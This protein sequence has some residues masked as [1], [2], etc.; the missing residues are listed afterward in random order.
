M[1]QLSDE[2]Y[3]GRGRTRECF[4][5][6]RDPHR[7][8]KVDFRNLGFRQTEKEALYYAKLARLK[9]DLVYNFIP[10][11][12]GMVETSRG[13][14]GVFDLIADEGTTRAASTMRQYITDGSIPNDPESW[15]T[16]LSQF[17]NRLIESGVIV[18]DIRPANL[19]AR[20][21]LDG[22]FEL[23]AIDGIG[24]RD[25][26][27]LCDYSIKFARRRLRRIISGKNMWSI[28]SM[29]K[30]HVKPPKP[31]PAQAPVEVSP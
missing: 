24:H 8:I 28:Q 12:H 18:R 16:Y 10:K 5:D 2:H 11:F 29:L 22:S 25:F 30:H 9:P 23:V 17:L 26:L 20:K 19:C 7:C 27:P 13:P 14:G 15:D 6:P 4:I 31:A 21:M 3:L 1:I